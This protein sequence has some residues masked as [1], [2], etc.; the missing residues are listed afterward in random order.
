MSYTTSLLVDGGV[1]DQSGVSGEN[2]G[3]DEAAKR[4][5]T[6]NLQQANKLGIKVVRIDGFL[7]LFGLE[8]N[9]FDAD[10]LVTPTP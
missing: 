8:E 6:I 3:W 5:R 4:R 10:H 1:P 7:E 9:Y 2:P